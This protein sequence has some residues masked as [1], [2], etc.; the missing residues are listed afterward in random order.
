MGIYFDQYTLLHF[1]VG[2]LLFINTL[3]SLF[4]FIEI[5]FWNVYYKS[6]YTFLTR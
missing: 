6:I 2:Y 1:S 3:H 4:E 5:L